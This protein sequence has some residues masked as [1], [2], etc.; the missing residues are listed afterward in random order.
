MYFNE[1]SIIFWGL[2]L[3]IIVAYMY[4][5]CV[6]IS[7]NIPCTAGELGASHIYKN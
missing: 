2:N 6:I 7:F 3:K 5:N 1:L 4:V